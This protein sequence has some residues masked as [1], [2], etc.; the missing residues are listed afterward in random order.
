MYKFLERDACLLVCGVLF[1]IGVIM[2]LAS[3][4]AF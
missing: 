4:W 2:L 1:N 3:T